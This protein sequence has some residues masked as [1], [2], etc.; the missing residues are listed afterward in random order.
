MVGFTEGIVVVAGAVDTVGVALPASDA[1][2]ADKAELG[3]VAGVSIAR[4]GRD[5]ARRLPVRPNMQRGVVHRRPRLSQHI[6]VDT[7]VRQS[8]QAETAQTGGSQHARA[9]R[10]QSESPF[11]NSFKILTYGVPCVVRRGHER[12]KTCGRAKRMRKDAQVAS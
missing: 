4:A 11:L 12:R 2:A 10:A 6:L 3:G 9:V 1:N 5:I 7:R 8:L